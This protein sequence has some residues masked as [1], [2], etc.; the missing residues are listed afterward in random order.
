MLT[1]GLYTLPERAGTVRVQP[2][3]EGYLCD[4]DFCADPATPAVW[5]FGF[6][7]LGGGEAEYDH[8][9]RFQCSYCGERLATEYGLREASDD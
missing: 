3:T 8:G 4:C 2:A 7:W 1:A 6:E 5:E 9:T